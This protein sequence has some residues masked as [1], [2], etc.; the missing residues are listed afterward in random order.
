MDVSPAAAISSLT[1]G[2]RE[3]SATLT[4]LK[5]GNIRWLSASTWECAKIVARPGSTPDSQVVGHQRLDIAG[6]RR[7]AV[8]VDDRLVVGDQHD[9]VDAEVLQPHAILQRAEVMAQVQRAGRPIA[10]QDAMSVRVTPQPR[11]QVRAAS[12]RIGEGAAR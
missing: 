1:V 8:A 5:N 2:L 10:R 11:F 9:Q 7:W 3:S 6:Q 12:L 4:R